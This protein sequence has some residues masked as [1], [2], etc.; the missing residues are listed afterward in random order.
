M[1]GA[2]KT[3][4]TKPAS[5]KSDAARRESALHRAIADASPTNIF[6]LDAESRISTRIQPPFKR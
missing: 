5:V 6:M 4:S 3:K 2:V 1:S